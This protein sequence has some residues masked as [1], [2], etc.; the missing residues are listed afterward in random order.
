M[1]DSLPPLRE[2]ISH[3]RSLLKSIVLGQRLRETLRLPQ[4][5]LGITT[6]RDVANLDVENRRSSTF[7]STSSPYIF[8]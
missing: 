8:T 7:K 5:R 6:V 2:L 3:F 4:T 1:I